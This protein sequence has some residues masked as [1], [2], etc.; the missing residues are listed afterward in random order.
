MEDLDH[1]DWKLALQE[2][3]RGQDAATK[4]NSCLFR[5]PEDE[6][7][8]P[9]LA[10]MVVGSFTRALSLLGYR[11]GTESDGT[12]SSCLSSTE[13]DLLDP[14]PEI[15]GK[16]DGRGRYK[17]RYVPSFCLEF[18]MLQKSPELRCFCARVFLGLFHEVK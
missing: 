2:L 11:D 17:R 10:Q 7:G 1:C 8:S 6:D 4:L 15:G 16:I 14:K 3:F 12:P 5:M 13:A 18:P 9:N